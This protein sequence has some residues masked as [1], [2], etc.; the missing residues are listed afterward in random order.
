MQGSDLRLHHDTKSFLNNRARRD[1]VDAA[2]IEKNDIFWETII[3]TTPQFV[4]SHVSG[5]AG[6]S[7]L[8]SLTLCTATSSH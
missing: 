4:L 8:P 7:A 2:V 6:V 1:L 5:G 3:A